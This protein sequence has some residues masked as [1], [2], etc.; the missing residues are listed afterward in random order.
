MI[1]KKKGNSK[2]LEWV[3]SVKNHAYWCA[4]SSDGIGTR[5][6]EKWL[7]MLNHIIDKHTDHGTVYKDCPHYKITRDWLKKVHATVTQ[8]CMQYQKL[9]VCN[10]AKLIP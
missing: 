8:F 7:S 2:V 5:V 1:G 9:A 4:A 3:Q 10:R 6:K